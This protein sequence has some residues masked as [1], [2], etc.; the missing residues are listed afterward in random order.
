MLSKTIHHKIYWISLSILAIGLPFSVFLMSVSQF[1][2]AT[3]WLIEGDFKNKWLRL[4]QNGPALSLIALFAIHLFWMLNTTDYEYGWHDIKIKLPLLVLS[5]LIGSSLPLKWNEFK[6]ILWTFVAAITASTLVSASIYF[7]LYHR[8]F[9]DIRQ[10]SIFISHIRL[11][12]LV[13]I[14]MII[15]GFLFYNEKESKTRF[16]WIGTIFWLSIFLFILNSYTGLIVS[17][18]LFISFLIWQVQKSQNN[19]LRWSFLGLLIFFILLIGFQFN[20]YIEQYNQKDALPNKTLLPKKTINGNFYYH[21]SKSE[22][23]EN[24]HYVYLFICDKELENE[25]NKRSEIEYQDGVN[26]QGALLK[27]TLLHYL[28]SLNYSKDSIGVWQLSQEDVQM[29][30]QGH[31]NYIYK[32]KFSIY[33]KLYP[34][35]KQIDDYLL[36][37][38]ASGGSL[39]QR[40]EYLKLSKLIIAENFW[41]GVGTGDVRQAFDEKYQQGYSQLKPEFQHR[42]HN[43]FVTFFISFG[44][45]GFVLAMGAMWA[46]LYWF[47]KRFLS[48]AIVAVLF[49]SMLNEDTLETQAGVTYFVFSILLLTVMSKLE[50]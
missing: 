4:K 49:L 42:A 5:L 36:V 32:S 8:P 48:M 37:G 44:F 13:N 41:W 9:N 50:K 34:I 40:F 3:N 47:E 33:S 28:T 46:P 16:I 1:L 14:A 21:T 15:S 35:F 2:I 12:L 7:D 23:F 22:I 10:I 31:S 20:S 24:G 6:W 27:H 11:S 43:Q 39:T 17:V 30:E 29:I 25:W 26:Q 19:L 38:Y 18:L 45:L